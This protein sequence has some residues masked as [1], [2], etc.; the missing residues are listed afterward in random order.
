MFEII[1]FENCFTFFNKNDL[2]CI[3]DFFV[4]IDNPRIDEEGVI[5]QNET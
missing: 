4:L 1:K 2:E 3:S 5:R